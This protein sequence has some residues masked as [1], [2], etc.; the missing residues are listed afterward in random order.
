MAHPIALLGLLGA[1][2]W[3][4]LLPGPRTA[5]APGAPLRVPGL[6]QEV[7]I[8]RDASG[9]A[10]VFASDERDAAFGLGVATAQ[11]RLW[12]METLRRLAGGRLAELMGD[13][14]VGGRRMHLPGSRILEVDAFYRSL[15]MYPVARQERAQHPPEAQEALEAFAEGVNAWIGRCRP[16]DL[17]PEFLLAGLDP[18][19]WRP[20]DSLVVGK[21]IGWLLSLAFAAKPILAALAARPA[22]GPL[23]PPDL[24]RGTCILGGASGGDGAGP[25]GEIADLELLA[26]R[27]LGLLGPGLGSNSWVLGGS[28]T[29]SGK[30]ILCNDPHLVFGLPAFWYPAALAT[31]SHR[32]IGVTIPGTPG[33]V[34]GRNDQLA[35]GFTAVMADDGDYYQETLDASGARYLRAGAWRAVE[36]VEETFRVRGRRAPEVRAL[37]F[38]RHGE[39]LCPLL[40]EAEGEAPRSFR[41]VGLEAW[42][43]VGA[44]LGMNR[45]HRVAEFEAA[46]RDFAVPAQNVLVADVHGG[47]AYFCA[48]KFPRRPFAGQAP[49]LLDGSR[50]EHAWQGYLDWSELPHRIAPPGDLL[51]TANN[52]TAAD[53]DPSLAGGYWE[54]PYR[55]SRIAQLLAGSARLRAEDMARIQVDDLSLQAAGLVARL[56]RPHADAL[57]DARARRAAGLLL[58]WDGRMAADSPGAALF[59]LFYQEVLRRG[60]R[61]ALEREAPGLFARY[62]GLLHFA[63]PAADSALLTADGAWFPEG[64]RPLAETCLAAAWEEAARRLGPDPTA[65]RWGALHRLALV[66]ALGRG[67]GRLPRILDWLFRLNRGPFPVPGDGMTVNLAAFSLVEPF[68]V[69]AGPSLRQIVDLADPEGARWV[70]PGGAS[71]DP[72]SPHYADQVEDWLQGVLRPMRIL[73]GEEAA[74]ACALR[75]LPARSLHERVRE[76]CGNDHIQ[77]PR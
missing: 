21:L 74:P 11:D 67:G 3:R 76:D 6:G 41:W 45:A 7:R 24:R 2:L 30:P 19:P 23:L 36:T 49:A 34:I 10:H 63:V 71:G 60:F 75:L 16:R 39:V 37:R 53:L 25:A 43:G 35:W 14:A 8:C 46:L 38:V 66:H 65:W 47:I 72:C 20:E 61:P 58:G 5:A 51:V 62:F 33:I 1:A 52:R 28:R 55:A 77:D 54:P 42:P 15:R 50:P 69:G 44:V 57:A 64:T 40:P 9:V 48:G 13:R 32:V 29:A 26:R 22:L 56:V 31:P 73:T 68:D 70:L 12:Q 18:E 59:H 4:R 27:T 17:P